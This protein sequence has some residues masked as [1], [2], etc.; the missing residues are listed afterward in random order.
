MFIEN[1]ENMNHGACVYA[2]SL[3]VVD[4]CLGAFT[5]NTKRTQVS[6]F[7]EMGVTSEYLI[8]M[9]KVE[10]PTTGQRIR[11]IFEPFSP[12]LW[13]VTSGVL[14]ILSLLYIVQETSLKEFKKSPVN[15]AAMALY[16]GSLSF[17][18]GGP[19]TVE[20]EKGTWGGR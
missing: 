13:G 14:M 8:V 19:E 16:Q 17:F 9:K 1:N 4:V 5:K 2:A 10:A 6:S 18:A 20:G 3:A 12:A 15:A 11:D 7:V